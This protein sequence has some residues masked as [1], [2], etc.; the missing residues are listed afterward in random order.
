[1]LISKT[2]H[3][4]YAW[5]PEGLSAALVAANGDPKMYFQEN[6]MHSFVCLS[7]A[8]FPPCLFIAVDMPSK[9]KGALNLER[10]H[11]SSPFSFAD[12]WLTVSLSQ[13][14]AISLTAWLLF[15]A[16]CRSAACTP[17]SPAPTGLFTK[18]KADIKLFVYLLYSHQLH[19]DKKE[20]KIGVKLFLTP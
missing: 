19:H 15:Q 1:M 20:D 5:G 13:R 8:A 3:I 7:I 16:L 6:D 11:P 4:L 10:L 9:A 17:T 2:R 14:K 18:I 12:P